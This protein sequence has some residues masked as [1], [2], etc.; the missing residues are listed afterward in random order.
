MDKS[1]IQYERAVEFVS[2]FD[3]V[4][5]QTVSYNLGLLIEDGFLKEV[6]SK[7][8]S[9]PVDK[10]QL[11]INRFGEMPTLRTSLHS[12]KPRIYN[13]PPPR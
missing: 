6:F 12:L 4:Y 3:E 5:Y 11:L 9:K 7:N 1:R 13:Q 10:A 2:Q 8:P